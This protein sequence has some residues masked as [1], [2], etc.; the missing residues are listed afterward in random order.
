MTAVPRNKPITY[1]RA[2]ALARSTDAE[3]RRALAARP[4]IGQEILYFL[5]EDGEPE[6]RLSLIHI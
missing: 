1:E 5:A 2:K 3:V 6:V 4:D